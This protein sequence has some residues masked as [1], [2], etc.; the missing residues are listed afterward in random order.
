MEATFY[1][2]MSRTVQMPA[3]RWKLSLR[4]VNP[5]GSRKRM[6]DFGFGLELEYEEPVFHG[7]EF[8]TDEILIGEADYLAFD[9]NGGV[10]LARAKGNGEL[11]VVAPS[12]AT[13][14]STPLETPAPR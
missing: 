3:F 8:E 7:I 9:Q 12:H 14:A 13:L 2:V 11:V 1:E 5:I 10:W 6:N 4:S